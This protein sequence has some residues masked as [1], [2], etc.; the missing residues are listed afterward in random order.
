MTARLVSCL[1]PTSSRRAH[2]PCAIRYFQRQTYRNTELIVLDEGDDS[3]A[4]LVP[5]DPSI[6]HIR[7]TR[8]GGLRPKCSAADSSVGGVAGSY[9]STPLS[10]AAQC[11]NERLGHA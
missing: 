6:C 10:Y 11:A 8:F 1:M 9:E 7:S 2:A 4:D 3:I 5:S